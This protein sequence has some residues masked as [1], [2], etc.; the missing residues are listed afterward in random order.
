MK[1]Y[2]WLVLASLI[3]GINAEKL[4]GR[5]GKAVLPIFQVVKYIYI[6][7][8]ILNGNNTPYFSSFPNDPCFVDGG[9]KNGT[10]YTMEECESKGG[11]NAGSCAEGFGVCCT[12]K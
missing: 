12:C 5:L 9:S 10:C 1:T 7:L 3:I 11:S 2:T 4:R 8:K 6:L